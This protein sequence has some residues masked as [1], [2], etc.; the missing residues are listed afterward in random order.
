MKTLSLSGD[1]TLHLATEN[2]PLPARVP[3]CV[4]LDLLRAGRIEDPFYRDREQAYGWVSDQDWSYRR[5]FTIAADFLD[6]PQ[7]RL[8]AEGLDT[9]AEVRVNGTPVAQTDNMFRTWEFDVKHLLKPGQNDIEV[10]F[11]SPTD[12]IR[13]RQQEHFLWHTGIDHH[14]ISGGNWVRKEQCQF[15]WDWGPMLPTMGIWRELSLVAFTSRLGDVHTQQ[16]HREGRVELSLAAEVEHAQPGQQVVAKLSLRGQAVT[17][18]T[19]QDGSGTLTVDHPELWWPNDL[20]AQPLYDM[21]VTL[22]QGGQTID[23][24]HQ[25]LGLRTLE[26]V[27]EKDEWGESFCFAANGRRFFAKGANWIPAD[28]FDGRITR[29]D[30]RDLLESARAAHMNCI[31]VWGGGKYECDAFYELCDELGICVWQDFMFACSAYPAHVP[32]FRASVQAEAEDNVRRLRHHA[33]LALWCGNN[34]LEQIPG[35][36]GDEPGTMNWADYCTL[37]DDLLGEVVTRLDP[38]RAYWPS[39]EHSPIGDRAAP[40]STDPR[41]GDAHLW[42]VWHGREP[43]EWYRTA[44]HRFCS[45]FGFQSFPEPRTV[46]TYTEPRDRNITSYV[47]ELHQRSPIGNSAIMDYGLSWFRLPVGF[48]A[49]LWLSQIIQVLGIQYAVE[50]WRRNMP[51]CMGAIYWQLNDCWPVASWA[52]IDYLHRWKA[53]HYA[54]R[55]FFAPVMLS[56]VEDL[57]AQSVEVHLSND[58]AQA[59]EGHIHWQLTTTSGEVIE[60][61]HRSAQIDGNA[62]ARIFTLDA[63]AALAKHG[64]RDVIAWFSLEIGERVVSRSLALFARPKHMDLPDPKLQLTTKVEGDR[65]TATVS[66]EKPALWTWLTH[67]AADIRWDDSFT[68]LSAGETRVFTGRIREQEPS[69]DASELRALS[70]YDT[71]QEA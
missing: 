25:R 60:Q 5:E 1:W 47:M 48:D 27:R 36:V 71:Y 57:K 31:R 15:G 38:V 22:R 12:Y 6:Q 65:I 67:P 49:T 42:K 70:L 19:L 28:S 41:W 9:F 16:I 10:R 50:H 17:E 32:A 43:F 39:S 52:S 66:A 4:H 61:G 2:D 3:G 35:I 58:Y 46:A 26:L 7:V 24:C 59:Q 54:A 53:L 18:V 51:R 34:E 68:H 64:P 40:A 21:E 13:A 45:E 33:C 20:G 44:F 30:L 23:R 69:F 62:S 11:T 55:R 37:F 56:T 14:R 63:A 29:E 8:R